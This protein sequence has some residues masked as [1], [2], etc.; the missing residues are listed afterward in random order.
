ME[1]IRVDLEGALKGQHVLLDP[2]EL[3]VGFLEDIETGS[4]RTSMDALSRCIVGGNLIVVAGGSVFPGAAELDRTA[5][6]Q[7]LR[8]LK[9]AEA[10]ALIDGVAGVW[11]LPKAS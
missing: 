9:A 10:K 6:R 4:I 8:R 7:S 11:A 2:D 1:S 3:N 5:L